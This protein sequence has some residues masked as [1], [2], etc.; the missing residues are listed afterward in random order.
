MARKAT[1]AAGIE[2]ERPGFLAQRGSTAHPL[3]FKSLLCQSIRGRPAHSPSTRSNPRPLLA[4]N[5]SSAM[6]RR[7]DRKTRAGV[8]LRGCP[9]R[10]RQ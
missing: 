6:E 9:S 2:E 1:T 7:V 3:K 4:A 10:W 5:Q 8:Q